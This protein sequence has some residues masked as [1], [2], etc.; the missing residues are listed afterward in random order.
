M[1]ENKKKP[2]VVN[3]KNDPRL[4]AYTDSLNLFNLTDQAAK[5][6]KDIATTSRTDDEYMRRIGF[7]P[8][9]YTQGN[10][11][12]T[13]YNRL[14]DEI[15]TLMIKHPTWNP[16]AY[17]ELPMT[18]YS[19]GKRRKH[20]TNV[21]Y[22]KPV[23]PVIFQ[24]KPILKSIKPKLEPIK[25]LG[26]KPMG[27]SLEPKL[28]GDVAVP[29]IPKTNNKIQNY[30]G[31]KALQIQGKPSG[32]INEG[33][34][35][36]R[37]EFRKGGW[38]DGMDNNIK[39]EASTTATKFRRDKPIFR[40][41]SKRE[42]EPMFDG[43]KYVLQHLEPFSTIK[44]ITNLGYAIY[45]KDRAEVNK[46]ILSGML[47]FVN[48]SDYELPKEVKDAVNRSEGQNVEIIKKR[49]KQNGGWLDNLSN[50]KFDM[51]GVLD[52]LDGVDK[53]T[54]VP[55]ATATAKPVVNLNF[56]V[57][58]A[59]KQLAAKNKRQA[60]I[61]MQVDHPEF[62]TNSNFL[63]KKAVKPY[64]VEDY[65]KYG[66]KEPGLQ[67]SMDPIDLVGTG[68]YKGVAKALGAKEV[69]QGVTKGVKGLVSD[70]SKYAEK[71]SVNPASSLLER[72]NLEKQGVKNKPN[73][74][75]ENIQDG[76]FNIT[77][78]KTPEKG[79][80]NVNVKSPTGKIQASINPDGTYGLSFEDANP[81]NAGKS[82]LKLKDQ[83]AGKTIYETKSFS[84]DSYAN[85]L[86]LKKK[87]SFEEAGF[88]PLNS[89]NKANNFLD[90]LVTKNSKE[91]SA[92]AN[93]KSEG[94]AIEGAKRMDDYMLKLGETTKS[95]VVN[96]NGKFE[97]HVPNYK[98]KVPEVNTTFK[99]LPG[100]SNVQQAGF[101][102]T[103]G[104][105]QKYPKGK[106]TEEEI[107]SF[108]NSDY[109]KQTTKEHLEAKN[110]YG[111]SWT[112][113]NYAEKNLDE[114]IATG[115]RSKVNPILYGGRN[116]G[117]ADYTIAGLAGTAYPGLAGI[118]GLAS[119]PPA[120]KNKVL[121][122]IGITST[123]G[124]LS[125]RDTTI[126]VTNRN[127]D[128]AKVNQTKDGQII[129]GGEFI[130]DVNNTVRKSKDWLTATDT[131]S[132]K[133]YPSKDVQSF[134]GVENGK[135]K[136]GKASDFN[137]ETEIVPRRFG[138]VN[139]NKAVM[140]NK[141][142]RLLDNEGK[143]IYQN[144]PNTGKFI[145][146]SP[147]TGKTQ[148][149]YINT[150]KSGVNKVN[151]FLKK[152]KDAQYIHLD[153]GRYEYY[154][155]NPEGLTEQDFKSYYEQDLKRKGNPGYN[156]IIKQNGGWLNDL[157]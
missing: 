86:N 7:S 21:E 112:L 117:A 19:D 87:L 153:N 25:P 49:I 151:D 41:E 22:K 13:E 17:T 69:A 130:E 90:D 64:S 118:M 123:P 66:I 103:K 142:M 33:D 135:F 137:P 78:R 95:K 94:A 155:I 141:E 12:N 42:V 127:M 85:V 134:Y 77:S 11:P 133:E 46:T 48:H 119:S 115:N 76:N 40:S 125:N 45:N 113:P 152:N 120:V 56:A 110:K 116:W 108:K 157:K 132:D 47:P 111:D 34:N 54:Q 44:D 50:N 140:N 121:S 102:N 4:K 101:I 154:G 52:G 5:L 24:N 20:L 97:V 16:I 65:K 73:I 96:N 55:D 150:G 93:F 105:F 114:A 15:N 148:F 129:I 146:Y 82:M 62:Y 128:F 124:S 58:P 79:L 39:Q 131:Y 29:E 59:Q 14:G 43:N 1:P 31:S 98:I 70:A 144:T 32:Y 23:Q 126:D 68:V 136:V 61:D 138:A 35:T 100:S 104:A 99:K 145:L 74:I 2:I 84:T 28:T 72:I 89:S 51:G 57:T 106:L 83:L 81:F 18:T 107:N 36:G 88:V 9:G 122:N 147:S 91:W 92:S 10:M 149:T 53:G 139:I 8:N 143:P 26:I 109:Y 71:K 80:V 3:D 30:T 37:Q 6:Y 156:L 27:T 67:T 75:K 63:D 60:E 38:L